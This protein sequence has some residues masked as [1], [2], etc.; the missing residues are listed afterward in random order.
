MSI[1]STLTCELAEYTERQKVAAAERERIHTET[2]RRLYEEGQRVID[3]SKLDQWFPGVD[4]TVVAVDKVAKQW[5]VVMPESP[6]EVPVLFKLTA[7]N[8]DYSRDLTSIAS[9]GVAMG[10]RNPG[11]ADR[12]GYGILPFP[13]PPPHWWVCHDLVQVAQHVERALE[14]GLQPP[15]YIEAP[16]LVACDKAGCSCREKT[17][18]AA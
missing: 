8:L 16:T 1:L 6:D 17:A 12:L 5:I 4:W 9:V 11:L 3:R 10:D 14:Q 13:A 7:M 15:Q 2:V 18:T